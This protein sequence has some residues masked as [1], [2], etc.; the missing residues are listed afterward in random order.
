ME[1]EDLV[2]NIKKICAIRGIYIRDMELALGFSPGLISR[3]IR[4]SPSIEKVMKVAEYLNVSL[5]ELMSGQV[6]KNSNDFIERLYKKTEE[7]K[8]EWS[9]CKSENPFSFPVHELKESQNANSVCC[10]CKYR[11]GFFLLACALDTEE[12]IEEIGLYLLPDKRKMPVQYEV[13][14]DELLPLYD[15]VRKNFIWE[16]DKKGAERLVDS[17]MKDEY[18]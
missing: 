2:K 6:E 10:Y 16:E 17:F 14:G 7:K 3:W 9:I 18:L 12:D 13:E 5:D 11:D 15:L 4:M 1:K 8:L